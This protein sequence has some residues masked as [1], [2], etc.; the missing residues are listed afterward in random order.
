MRKTI[1]LCATCTCTRRKN[2][3]NAK[4]TNLPRFQTR[5]RRV[6]MTLASRSF[7]L[8]CICAGVSPTLLLTKGV[9]YVL[10]QMWNAT[11]WMHP[12]GF[13]YYPDGAHGW[14]DNAELPEL[15][16]PNPD[17]CDLPQFQCNPGEG[18]QQA[19][20]Y[21]VNG[22]M[23]SLDNWNDEASGAGL[24]V[25]EPLFQVRERERKRERENTRHPETGRSG[26]CCGTGCVDAD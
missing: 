25:Y 22:K 14:L 1:V 6:P 9:E 20:L 26:C 21:D 13:A 17:L 3:R 7:S 24:D 10:E 18:I 8:S 4:L 19:P 16:S 23:D 11:N 5:H 12:L 15:E 2:T